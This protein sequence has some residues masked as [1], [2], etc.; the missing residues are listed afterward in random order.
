MTNINI[1]E[2]VIDFL[3]ES[4]RSHT[5]GDLGDCNDFSDVSQLAGGH[6]SGRV[7]G[8]TETIRSRW[9][10]RGFVED[11]CVLISPNAGYR[12]FS[13]CPPSIPNRFEPFPH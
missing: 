9:G 11:R 1:H 10:K 4:C 7:T 8:H 13:S 3:L 5:L 6:I 2:K 12:Q